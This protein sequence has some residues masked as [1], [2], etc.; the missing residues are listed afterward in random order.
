[1]LKELTTTNESLRSLAAPSSPISLISSSNFQNGTISR[2]TDPAAKYTGVGAAMVRGAGY[3]AGIGTVSE[4]FTIGYAQN[5]SL[6]QQFLSYAIL[7][8]LRVFS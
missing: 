6:K 2:D 7:E 1:M 3:R 4:S 8:A 5:P